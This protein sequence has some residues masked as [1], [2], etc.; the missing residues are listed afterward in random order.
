MEVTGLMGFSPC[1]RDSPATA[2]RSSRPPGRP[3][4][5]EDRAARPRFVGTAHPIGN[6]QRQRAVDV[7]GAQLVPQFAQAKVGM[8]ALR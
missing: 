2:R 5:I 3:H 4:G 7:A 1:P 8:T 6:S